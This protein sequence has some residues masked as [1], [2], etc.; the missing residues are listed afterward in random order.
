MTR[1][2]LFDIDN[3][4]LMKKPSVAEKVFEIVAPTVPGMT[5][6]DVERAYA[7]SELWQ[8]EQIRK[9]NET[10]IRMPDEEYL[11]NVFRVYQQALM[12]EDQAYEALRGVFMGDYTK[13][14]ET[15]PGAL[16]TLRQLKSRGFALGIVSNNRPA[17]RTDLGEQGLT[18]FFDSVVISEEVGL[19]KPDPKILELACRQ[20]GAACEESVYVGDHPFDILCAHSANMAAVW[21]PVNSFMTVPAHIGPPEH[22][23]SALAE[24]INV[25]DQ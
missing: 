12:L 21:M 9:E 20:L 25:L 13:R 2:V 23:V 16:E 8:G 11:Q 7:Q 19:Y 1:C 15:A 3:T 6:S 22:T 24:I 17:V 5:L 10:G 14:Y 18:E 4:L